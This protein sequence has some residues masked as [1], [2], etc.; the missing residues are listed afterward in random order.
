MLNPRS[1]IVNQ[2]IG[3]G[4]QQYPPNNFPIGYNGYNQGYTGYYGNQ[5]NYNY[6]NPIYQQNLIRQQ[7]EEAERIHKQQVEEQKRISRIAHAYS[8]VEISEQE[9]NNIYDPQST[10]TVQQ[11]AA[12][13]EYNKIADTVHS[14]N[15]NNSKNID[16]INA[17]NRAN[18][19][20]KYHDKF[21]D[22]N[23]GLNEFL[24]SAGSLYI[25][26]LLREEKHK[27]RDLSGTYDSK[28]YQQALRTAPYAGKFSNNIDDNVIGLPPHLMNK[29]KSSYE[30]RRQMFIASIMNSKGAVV[31]G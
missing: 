20:T 18:S 28:S 1:P 22:P 25:D 23:C 7:Q 9:L 17:A 16:S 10:Q 15:S 6:Y 11:A 27:N 12:I 13:Y 24:Q 26:G 14:I 4:Y 31:N 29:A 2:L 21:I 3:G 19:I 8:G 5:V 30:E